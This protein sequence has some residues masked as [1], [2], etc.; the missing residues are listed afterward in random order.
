MDWVLC[1]G[2]ALFTICVVLFIIIF[3]SSLVNGERWA[4]IIFGIVIMGLVL[5]WITAMWHNALY[6]NT[7]FV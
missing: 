3:V 6:L 2:L 5:S 4:W 7:M 1:F